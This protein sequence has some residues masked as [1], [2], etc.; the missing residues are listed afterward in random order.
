MKG[1]GVKMED[2]RAEEVWYEAHKEEIKKMNNGCPIVPQCMHAITSTPVQAVQMASQQKTQQDQIKYPKYY[3]QG[4]IEP[5]Q[6]TLA[7]NLNFCLGNVVKY[8]TRAGKKPGNDSIQD[9]EKAKQY[10]EFE[11]EFRKLHDGVTA[12]ERKRVFC[13]HY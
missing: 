13:E 4:S 7:N 10:L 9:L 12:S 5:I 8:V 1:A 3:I 11:I 6:Y 2:Q